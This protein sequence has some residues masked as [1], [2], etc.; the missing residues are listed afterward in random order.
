MIRT[1]GADLDRIQTPHVRE[2]DELEA[3]AAAAAA[4]RVRRPGGAQGPARGLDQGRGRARRGARPRAAGRPAGPRQDLPGPDHRRGARRPVRADRRPR[5]GAQGRHRGVPDRPGAA[6]GVLRRRDPPPPARAWRRRSIRR[7]R[8]GELPITFGAGAGGEGRHAADPAVHA[9]RRDHPRRPAH[10]A[11]A[12]P[13]RH[14]APA[15]P[16]RRRRAGGDRRPQRARARRPG[17]TWTARGRSPSAPA[18]R[19]AWPTACSSAC[20]TTRRSTA[21]ARSTPRAAVRGAGRA[22]ASTTRAWTAWTARS[23]TT[24]C[25]RF[26]G[27]PVGLSTLAV[28]VHE[29]QDTIEDV[30]EPYLLQRGLHQA[31]AARALRDAARLPPPRPGTAARAD[32][33]SSSRSPIASV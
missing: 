24:I 32:R 16:L 11:A 33:A 13:L 7:W 4:G 12:R 1:P 22:W 18:A 15:G 21:T 25:E 27:G 20:A 10:D 5:A 19:R 6:R 28:A 9:D 8:T 31:H 23:C 14:P 2:D 26:G 17:R 29:E 30:Y 3:L